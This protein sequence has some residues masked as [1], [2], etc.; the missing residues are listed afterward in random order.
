MLLGRNSETCLHEI[1]FH[2]PEEINCI[3]LSKMAAVNP[4]SISL[5]LYCLSQGE[6]HSLSF[7]S[8]MKGLD[9]VTYHLWPMNYEL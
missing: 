5:S 4:P 2:F 7:K 1:R 3:V 8:A 6:K 9:L